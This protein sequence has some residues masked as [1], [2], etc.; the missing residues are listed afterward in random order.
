MEEVFKTSQ[1]GCLAGRPLK[2]LPWDRENLS[3]ADIFSLLVLILFKAIKC[4]SLFVLKFN[5]LQ[6]WV[7]LVASMIPGPV[8]I[9]Q[10]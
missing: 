7:L 1:D 5:I 9:T 10:L 4:S 3:I 6:F 2:D 8:G